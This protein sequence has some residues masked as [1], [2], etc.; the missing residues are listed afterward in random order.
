MTADATDTADGPR[1]SARRERT[2][3]RLLEELR[4]ELAAERKPGFWE[5][6]FGRQ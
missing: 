6:M 3:E 1:T 2:R 4:A 5:R